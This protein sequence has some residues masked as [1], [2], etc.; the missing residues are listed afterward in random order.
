[1]KLIN[2]FMYESDNINIRDPNLYI[3]ICVCAHVRLNDYKHVCKIECNVY[4]SNEGRNEDKIINLNG[5]VIGV[6]RSLDILMF[7]QI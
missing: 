6:M 4:L 2:H 1:M 5:V 7:A 3:C